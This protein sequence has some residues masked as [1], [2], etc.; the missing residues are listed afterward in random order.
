M[1]YNK[2]E[3][4]NE[5]EMVFNKDITQ[6]L[7]KY[8]SSTTSNTIFSIHGD[9]GTGK[10]TCIKV[11]M[12]SLNVVHIEIYDYNIS[13]INFKENIKKCFSINKTQIVVFENIDNNKS[14]IISILNDINISNHKCILLNIDKDFDDI[15]KKLKS[16]KIICIKTSVK[17]KIAYIQFINMICQKE[18]IKI[19]QIYVKNNLTNNIRNTIQIVTSGSSQKLFQNNESICTKI[20]YVFSNKINLQIKNSAIS[21]DISSSVG[22][23]HNMYMNSKLPIEKLYIISDCLCIGDQIHT[24]IYDHQNWILMDYV[25][26]LGVL[27][28]GLIMSEYMNDKENIKYEKGNL[29]SKYSNV[30]TKYQKLYSLMTIYPKLT[31]TKTV[32]RVCNSLNCSIKNNN[33]ELYNYLINEYFPDALKKD[34]IQINNMFSDNKNTK[35]NFT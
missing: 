21:S 28:P 4:K 23:I 26:I 35:I 18:N 20:K 12:K 6:S 8:I 1:L 13:K 27:K 16:K 11:V 32:R 25:G 2:Y 19:S 7:K 30:C 22:I 5:N 33:K 24:Y 34:I 15:R 17:P 29:W 9:E 14:E 3:P 31:N 10:S